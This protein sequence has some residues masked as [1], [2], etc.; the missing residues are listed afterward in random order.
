M[1]LT[2]GNHDMNMRFM[3]SFGDKDGTYMFWKP[4]ERMMKT[5]PAG[6]EPTLSFFDEAYRYEYALAN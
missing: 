1:R 2:F 6:Y 5:L 3:G 4:S